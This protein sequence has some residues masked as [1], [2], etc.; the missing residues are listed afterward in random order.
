M[1]VRVYYDYSDWTSIHSRTNQSCTQTNENVRKCFISQFYTL[2]GSV[3][4]LG[5]PIFNLFLFIYLFINTDIQSN[6]QYRASCVN[7]TE[8]LK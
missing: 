5:F 6:K 1:H 8:R 2:Y 7:K 4:D 3:L